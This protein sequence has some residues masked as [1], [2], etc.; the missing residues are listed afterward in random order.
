M[1]KGCRML[2]KSGMI[3][4]HGR[5]ARIAGFSEEAKICQLE[6]LG[7]VSRRYS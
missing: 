2:L 6:S 5:M 1:V 3:V 7:K 4:C